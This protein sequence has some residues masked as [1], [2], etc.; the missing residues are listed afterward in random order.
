MKQTIDPTL[1]L[2]KKQ[3]ESLVIRNDS[4]GKRLRYV[5]FYDLMG[6][7]FDKGMISRY[8]RERNLE[9]ITITGKARTDNYRSNIE[10]VLNPFEMVNYIANAECVF[11]SS[12]H[13]LVFSLIFNKKV[14]ASFR[15][16]SSRAVSLLNTLELDNVLIEPMVKVVS[17]SP[18][19]YDKCNQIL[20][21][22]R[23]DSE[24]WLGNALRF[25]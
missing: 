20:A 11:T 24:K 5:L 18:V 6:G 12:Y 23:Y 3:W 22:M 4:K 15:Y 9:L 13:G 2:D 1:L 21:S 25:S 7:S 8:A 19:D 10:A 17:D 16:N 14:F